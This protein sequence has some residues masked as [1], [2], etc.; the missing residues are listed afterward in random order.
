MEPMLSKR[1]VYGAILI[2]AL[3][4]LIYADQLLSRAMPGRA[5][6]LVVTL[7]VAALVALGTLEMTSLCKSAGHDPLSRLPMLINLCL[8]LEPFG[9]HNGWSYR[10]PDPTGVL[11]TSAVFG[12]FVLIALRR[13]TERAIADMAVTLFIVLYLG[14]LPQHLIHL[15]LESPTRTAWLLLYFVAT[16]KISDIGAYFTGY[17]FGKHKMIPWLSPKKT[18]EGLAGGIAASI[19]MAILFPMIAGGGDLQA[20]L[21]LGLNWPKAAIFGLFMAVLGQAGDLLESLI[22]R[23]AQAKDSA[24]AV[25]AFGGVLDI[26]DSLLLT[27]PLACWMLLK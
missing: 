4:G 9:L 8:I 20:G 1:L 5:E 2:A 25:P 24:S 3:V 27:A 7:I 15:R 6:G 26:I 10:L 11:L 14:L 21:G 16:V 17:F 12:T 19:A 18:F 22:K 13:R 23:D